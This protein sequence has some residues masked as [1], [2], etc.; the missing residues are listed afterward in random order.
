MTS[1]NHVG[2]TAAEAPLHVELEADGKEGGASFWR[3]GPRG[4]LTSLEQSSG[5]L[6]GGHEDTPHV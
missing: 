5:S 3:A 4:T 6:R 2:I 1:N